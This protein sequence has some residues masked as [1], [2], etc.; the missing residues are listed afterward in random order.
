MKEEKTKNVSNEAE[1][2]ALRIHNVVG[3]S[4]QLCEHQYFW[5][6]S[7]DDECMKRTCEKCGHK[8]A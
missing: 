8:D 5:D 4:E 6:N 7:Q 3:Q 2:E 1:A